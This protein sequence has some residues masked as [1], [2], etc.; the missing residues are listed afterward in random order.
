MRRQVRLPLLWPVPPP[1]LVRVGNG[2][3]SEGGERGEGEKNGPSTFSTQLGENA[4][5]CNFGISLNNPPMLSDIL[6]T[7]KLTCL[8]MLNKDWL[9][10]SKNRLAAVMD[11]Y[12]DLNKTLLLF[13]EAQ[14]LDEF[15]LIRVTSMY[16]LSVCLLTPFPLLV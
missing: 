8:E 11:W 14:D 12:E 7:H 5:G 4:K 3:E 10:V 16:S 15:C 9:Q 6:H 2:R 13:M 1:F